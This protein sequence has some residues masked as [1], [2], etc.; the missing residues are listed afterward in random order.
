MGKLK[1]TE[2]LYAEA[3]EFLYEEAD[4]LDSGRFR[5]WLGLMT[6][7]LTYRV[8]VVVTEADKAKTPYAADGHFFF[9]TLDSLTER[10]KR[11]ETGF[12]WAEEPPSRTRRLISN[13]RVESDNPNELRV[14]SNF[15]LYR[16]RGDS[17][18]ADILAGER[19]DVLRHVDGS[20]RL[21]CRDVF[22]TQSVLGMRNLSIFL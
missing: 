8:P 13:V 2:P 18:D 1:S 15:L 4:L 3:V 22:L 5:D 10:V 12:A 7:D 11:L 20:W 16:S 21:A 17:P 6:Q 14:K 9:E 19:H